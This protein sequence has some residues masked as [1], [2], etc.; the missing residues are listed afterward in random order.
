MR[1]EPW[2]GHK[3]YKVYA[4]FPISTRNIRV[5]AQD[6]A[7]NGGSLD[8][9]FRKGVTNL[10]AYF[11]PMVVIQAQSSSAPYVPDFLR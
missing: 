7:P 11:W 6:A 9:V 8:A 1:S 3:E 4:Q 2:A 5:N 10:S